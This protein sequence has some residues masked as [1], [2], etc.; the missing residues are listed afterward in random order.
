MATISDIVQK[1]REKKT[2][3]HYNNSNVVAQVATLTIG[4][5]QMKMGNFYLNDKITTYR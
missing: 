3:I 1:I 5:V 4:S 2:K